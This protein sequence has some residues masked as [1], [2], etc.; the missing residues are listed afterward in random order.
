MVGFTGR[1]TGPRTG[2]ADVSV[3]AAI[4]GEDSVGTILTGGS[5]TVVGGGTT[6]TGVGVLFS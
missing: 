3:G 6:R 5:T 4:E 2:G 1:G